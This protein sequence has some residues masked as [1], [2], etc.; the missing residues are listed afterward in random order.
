MKKKL[1]ITAL[2]FLFFS[3]VIPARA[4]TVPGSLDTGFDPGTGLDTD[5]MLNLSVR[6]MAVQPDGKVIIGGV[7]TEV[8]GV[9]YNYLAR[10]NA[11]GSVDTSFDIGTGANEVVNAVAVQPDGKIIVGGNFTELNG[12]AHKKSLA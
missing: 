6:A 2:V 4:D 11:D 8:D 9:G 1:T 12:T 3:L 10:L 5:L 7:F